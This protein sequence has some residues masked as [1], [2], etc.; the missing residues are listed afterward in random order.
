MTLFNLTLPPST[1]DEIEINIIKNNCNPFPFYHN[2]S[3][4]I[5]RPS[6]FIAH[7]VL[8]LALTIKDRTKGCMKIDNGDEQQVMQ[9]K[10]NLILMASFSL[11]SPP[12]SL[13][14]DH[15][16]SKFSFS[17]LMQLKNTIF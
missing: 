5:H 12:K 1:L 4:L 11:G 10:E 9:L 6:K 7:T 2:L 15:N 13:S 17:V 3:S 8:P 14:A 16:Q